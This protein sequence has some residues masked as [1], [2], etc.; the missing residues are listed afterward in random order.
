MVILFS[1]MTPG[2]EYSGCPGSVSRT[3]TLDQAC[4]LESAV[5]VNSRFASNFPNV[6]LPDDFGPHTNMTGA[7]FCLVPTSSA[8]FLF[9]SGGD[10]KSRK[11]AFLGPSSELKI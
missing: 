2:G 3:A 4:F 11:R 8:S 5:S 10:T 9:H 1:E 7:F 6:D